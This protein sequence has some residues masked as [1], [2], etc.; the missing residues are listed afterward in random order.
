MQAEQFYVEALDNLGRTAIPFMVGGAYALREY[1]DIYRDTKD[2]DIFCKASDYPLLL[3]A[4]GRQG[5]DT[6]IT[7]ANWL[8][9][10]RRGQHFIDIIFNSGNGICPVDD[11]WLEHAPA[12]ELLGRSVKLIPAEEEIWTKS[13]VQGRHRFDGADVLHIL[14]KRGKSLDWERLLARF[15]GHWEVL[16]AHLLTFQFVYPSERDSVP[17]AVMGELLERARRQLELPV[18]RDRICRGPLLS[19]TDYEVDIDTWGYRWLVKH[20]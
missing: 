1:A 5:Y 7:D 15:E 18:P 9:K 16:L 19:R 8:A 3:D 10:A 2:L 6:E 4:L 17:P 20:S 12:V 11:G 14:R 13:Y